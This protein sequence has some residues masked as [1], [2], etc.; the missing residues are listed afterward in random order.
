[1]RYYIVYRFQCQEKRLPKQPFWWFRLQGISYPGVVVS[2]A[3]N[4]TSSATLKSVV[5]NSNVFAFAF[6]LFVF[7]VTPRVE[8]LSYLTL[9]KPW[10]AHQKKKCNMMTNISSVI[11][12]KSHVLHFC[13]TYPLLVDLAG[14][15]PASR[16][17][18]FTTLSIQ[19]LQQFFKQAEC[20]QP[21]VLSDPQLLQNLHSVL[22]VSS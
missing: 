22:L 18:Y 10:Q 9:S 21:V 20:C 17:P 7:Y 4:A 6:T 5:I 1:M 13:I 19:G 11:T 8:S 16:M 2:Q 14:V 12:I 15:E 3:T